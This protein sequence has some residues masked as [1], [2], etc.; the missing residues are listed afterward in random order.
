MKDVGPAPSRSRENR[1][2]KPAEGVAK[3]GATNAPSSG[4]DGGDVAAPST[5]G[6][7]P[8]DRRAGPTG[9]NRRE[10][11][12]SAATKSGDNK[13][14]KPYAPRTNQTRD[15]RVQRPA[16]AGALASA[17]PAPRVT[18]NTAPALV[19][20]PKEGIL[21]DE[22]IPMIASIA[23]QARG[24]YNNPANRRPYAGRNPPSTV[25]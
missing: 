3:E 23:A 7:N 25:H 21:G 9:N 18:E 17:P 11:S 2:R 16:P 19:P 4:R 5:A 10:V 20:T 1:H 13:D 6:T 15:A 14:R 8:R 22:S 24:N 12:S